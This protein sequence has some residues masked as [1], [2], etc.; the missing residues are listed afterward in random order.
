MAL[1][2]DSKLPPGLEIEAGDSLWSARFSCFASPCQVLL[3]QCPRALAM[4]LASQAMDEAL[5]IQARF[6]RYREDSWLAQLHQAAGAWFP[7]DNEIEGLLDVAH[8]AF[9]LSGGRF[10]ISSGVLRHAWTFAP[11]AQAPTPAILEPLLARVG[12]ERVERQA[13][14]IRL[15]P[16]MELDLGGIGKEYAVDRAAALVAQRAPGPW[17]VNYGG[18][19]CAGGLL[20]QHSAW[21]VGLDSPFATGEALHSLEL[22]SGALA[23]S[24]DARRHLMHKGQRLGHIL[25]AR[26]GWPPPGAPPSVTVAAATCTEAGLFSTIGLLMGS[27][28][29]EWLRATGKVFRVLRV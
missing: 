22:R 29:E 15:P 26:T 10:D 20:P 16:G 11:N 5:R 12:W 6:S 3:R 4:E 2:R 7:T 23:T 21:M 1:A 19:L 25:D 9:L 14:A 13:G 17:L 27:R 28:A 18:D 24:G 8:Q